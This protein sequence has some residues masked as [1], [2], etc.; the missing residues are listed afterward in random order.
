MIVWLFLA[1]KTLPWA[2]NWFQSIDQLFHLA[3]TYQNSSCSQ[4]HLH[5]NNSFL[6]QKCDF[7]VQWKS[8]QVIVCFSCQEHLSKLTITPKFSKIVNHTKQWNMFVFKLFHLNKCCTCLCFLLV[9]AAKERVLIHWSFFL[10]VGMVVWSIVFL[11]WETTQV[12]HTNPLTSISV[13]SLIYF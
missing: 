3:V 11:W 2:L 4:Q 13:A 6:P 9:L 12:C 8:R 10:L 7:S 5:E 1:F